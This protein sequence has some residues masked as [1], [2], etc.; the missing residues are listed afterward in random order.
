MNMSTWI[1]ITDPDDVELDPEAGRI[2]ILYSTDEFGNNYVTLPGSMIM[3]LLKEKT[4]NHG[5]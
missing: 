4:D 5:D 2:N 3:D 1:E